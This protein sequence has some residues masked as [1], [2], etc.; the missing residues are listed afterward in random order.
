MT[1]RLAAIVVGL[2]DAVAWIVLALL[3]FQSGSDPATKGLDVAAGAVVTV[4]FLVTGAPALVLAYIGRA[5]RTA[6][7][8]ALAFPAVFVLLFVAVVIAFA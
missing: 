1:L 6:L 2:L 3:T 4:L 8:L 5:P 7:V